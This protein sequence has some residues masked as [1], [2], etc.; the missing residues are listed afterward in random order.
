MD[1]HS[2]ICAS[3]QYPYSKDVLLDRSTWLAGA[4][5][6]FT[7]AP[8]KAQKLIL[9]E[10]LKNEHLRHSTA[11]TIYVSKEIM[12]EVYEAQGTMPDNV[13]LPQDV[14]VPNGMLVFEEPLAYFLAVTDGYEH[15]SGLPFSAREEW[16]LKAVQFNV[17]NSV[18]YTTDDPNHH[19]GIEVRFFGNWNSVSYPETNEMLRYNRDTDCAELTRFGLTYKKVTGELLQT[20][21]ESRTTIDSMEALLRRARGAPTSM[22]DAT[23]F[24]FN[25]AT[26]D[27]DKTIGGMKKFLIALFRLTYSY[28]AQTQ[29]EAPRHVIKRAKRANRKILENG[30][31]TVLRLR[32]VE[33]ENGGGTHSSPKYAFRVRGHWKRAYLR[34]T[35]L[36]VGDPNA[37]RYLYVSDYIKGKT[38]NKEFRES[39]RVINITN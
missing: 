33:Y 4:L 9:E 13:L 21:G 11:Q 19:E 38:A 28:L 22:F 7:K 1:V 36:P 24:R 10:T 35:G 18:D 27:Y 20:L 29:E 34:S 14:F 37:Y 5:D 30:Y 39:T 12:K 25:Y 2:Q 6:M 23:F 3:T 17:I 8:I 32:R 31:L 26:E 15:L 16:H